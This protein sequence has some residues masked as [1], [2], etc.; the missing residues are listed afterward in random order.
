[1]TAKD[2]KRISLEKAGRPKAKRRRVLKIMALAALAAMAVI[3]GGVLWLRSDAG[4][5]FLARRAL[6]AMGAKGLSASWDSLSGPIPERLALRGLVLSDRMGRFAYLESLELRLAARSLLA[7]L[8]DV[9]LLS[10]QGLRLERRPELPPGPEKDGRPTGLPPIDV[11]ARFDVAGTMANQVLAPE[12]GDG[13]AGS[14]G[15]K[16]SLGLVDGSLAVDLSAFFLDPD[17]RGLELS[18]NLGQGQ[19]G[20]PDRLG[21]DLSARDGPGG[22]LSHLL[23]RPDWPSWKLSL[24]GQGPL[25]GWRGQASLELDLAAKGPPGEGPGQNDG[26]PAMTPI[27]TASLWLAGRTGTIR[28]DLEEGLEVALKAEA[29]PLALPA[30]I[31]GRL[32]P[33]LALEARARLKGQSAMGDLALV[34]PKA[35]LGLS[36][37]DLDMERDGFVLKARGQAS[38]DQSLL[39]K[40]DW[41][42]T[43]M[44][45]TPPAPGQAAAETVLAAAGD[46]PPGPTPAGRLEI[47]CDLAMSS[48]GGLVELSGLSLGG[49]GLSLSAD[50]R[51]G[52]LGSAQASLRLELAPDS[53]W[54]PP[55]L[56]LVGQDAGKTGPLS[57][58]ASISRDAQGL[59]DLEADL[60]IGELASLA[61]PWGGQAKARVKA[62]GPL[63]DLAVDLEI[64]GPLVRGPTEDFPDLAASFRGQV[65][66]LPAL[67]GLKGSLGL[68]TGPFSS[69][70]LSLAAGLALDLAPAAPGPGEDPA[71]AAMDLA[72]TDLDL[73]AGREKEFLDLRSPALSVSL[74]PGEVPAL[75]GSL[76]LTVGDWKTIVALTGL[77][78]RG[79]PASLEA[80][81]DPVGGSRNS[82]RVRLDLPE[83]ALGQ[84]LALRGLR[85]DLAANDYLTAPDLDLTLE[86]GASR[87]GPV[88]LAK[89][90]V[91]AQ[92]HG[93]SASLSADLTAAGG[94]EF[95]G[96]AATG[97]ME[98]RKASISSLRI[99]SLPQLPGGLRL[100]GPVALDFRDGL[101]VGQASLV[102]GGGGTVEFS[103]SLSPLA[104]K[105]RLSDV[106]LA[107]LAGVM[108]GPPQG[109]ASL[110]L[111]YAS[112]G[113]GSFDLKAQL[114]TPASLESLPRSLDVTA[115]GKI[116]PSSMDGRISVAARR[117]R[118]V[119]LDFRLPLVPAGQFFRPNPD[120]PLSASLVWKGPVAPLWGLIGLADRSLTG[121]LDL[122]AGLEGTLRNPRP[123][124]RL[125]VANGT[126][127][128]LVMG[129]LLSDFNLE[130]HEQG[131]G[132]LRLLAEAGDGL[133][134]KLALE[135][136]VR[137]LALPPSISVRG[138]MRRLAPLRR[139]DASAIITGL[140]SLDGP[141]TALRIGA[142]AVVE[143]AEINLD[144]AK[145]RGSVTTLDLE[146]RLTRVSHGPTLDLDIDLPR[147]VFIRGKGLDSEW[148]GHVSVSNPGGRIM[149]NGSLRP[150]RGTFDL[151][152]KQF[153]FTGG[154]IQFLNNPRINPSI[155]VELT[156]QTG[157][158][159]AQVK[160]TG[161]VSRPVLAFSSQPPFPSDE[162]LSQVLFGKKVSQLSRVEALQLANSLRVMAGL[163]GDLG[164]TVLGTMR[165]ALGLSVL[166]VGDGGGSSDNRILGGSSFRDDLSRDDDAQGED[167]TTIE[168]GR[169]IGDN[170]YVGLEQNLSDNSTGVR[171]EVELAPNVSLQSLTT[172]TSNRVGLGWKRDY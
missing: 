114:A 87:L 70:P 136:T 119:S 157:T 91:V 63:G 152:S 54:W 1:M 158:L 5:D 60:D 83:L 32:G 14:L 121:E 12:S 134:G 117:F 167:S 110:S 124:V 44:T 25:D 150:I 71:G 33:G 72:L 130:V 16:G 103:G 43:D 146:E 11:R 66:G 93:Q 137:P 164:L 24:A 84:D 76:K 127:Q 105:A 22:P 35:R 55:V 6:A 28:K 118:E 15:L 107:N 75:G 20:A 156:R 29:G 2:E 129:L 48:R 131:D 62:R 73:S 86:L 115:T 138:Q 162:V 7:G 36:A 37:I 67:R 122:S 168:A 155:N 78:L 8:V 139:D 69:G 116:A 34:A 111:D 165:D 74:R 77:D 102:L 142:R 47:D 126:Y 151:L 100:A 128:D 19:D 45:D 13:A 141:F 50:G 17:G 163:G 170:I 120:G 166:R 159:M 53:A 26:E 89:G 94:S 61:P 96:L 41:P 21:L 113:Q 65:L 97:D 135:G 88:E 104:F 123:K 42:E 143:Q 99:A 169:Y 18:A 160:V 59:L 30:G 153:T 9:E 51:A 38:L 132:N 112:G 101:H 108:E 85:L 144:M 172:S 49:Q 109:K 31:V 106:S 27:A 56:A 90:R 125:Y 46:Q 154:D 10:A 148:G 95:L 79:A 4:L 81:L 23:D 147:Q 161:T 133:G 149:L 68:S 58:E 171:V 64:D 82:A 57:L 3:L 92:G 40:G 52:P 145:G 98:A 39:A 140:A 80:N